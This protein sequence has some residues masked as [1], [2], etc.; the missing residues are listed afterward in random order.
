MIY[1]GNLKS[2]YLKNF[3]VTDDGVKLMLDSVVVERDSLF[4]KNFVGR[5]VNFK[6]DTHLP[7]YSE[8]ETF[9]MQ[10]ARSNPELGGL[11]CLYADYNSIVPVPE[12]TRSV[13]QLKKEFK[14]QRKGRT[15]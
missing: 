10:S 13:K 2:L 6:Y 1:K 9:V 4:Y 11:S 5:L 14:V 8:A 3:E 12:E 7:T 15:K